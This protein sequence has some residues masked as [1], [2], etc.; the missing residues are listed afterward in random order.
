M[1]TVALPVQKW[2]TDMNKRYAGTLEDQSDTV[3]TRDGERLNCRLMLPTDAP[4]LVDL[5][6]RLSPESRRRRFHYPADVIEYS[7]LLE[8]ATKLAAVDN[9]T[10][11]GAVVVLENADDGEHIVGVARLMRPT[12]EP[13]SPEAEAAITVRDDYHGRGLGTELLRRMIL[14][15]KRMQVKVV[16]AE[17]EADNYVAL[18]LFR[19]LNLVTESQTSHAE[20]TMRIEVPE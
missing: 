17:I 5:F 8:M 12:G 19:E 10:Q 13:A 3:E 2:Q 18:R 14:L 7:A 20:T 11:N 1:P 9:R 6:Q 15:A 16:V 4:L